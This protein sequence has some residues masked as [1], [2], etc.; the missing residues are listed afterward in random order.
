MA[1]SI[2]IENLRRFIL[3]MARLDAYV[4]QT[5]FM[6]LVILSGYLAGCSTIGRYLP[7]RRVAGELVADFNWCEDGSAFL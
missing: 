5:G 6:F 1:C 7:F 3:K 2:N 4:Y